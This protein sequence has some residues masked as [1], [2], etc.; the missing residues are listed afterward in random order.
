M[1]SNNP[2]SCVISG[3]FKFK[4]EIDETYDEFQDNN[5]S[6]LAPEKGRLFLPKQR[7]IRLDEIQ[8]MR[9]LPNERDINPNQIEKEFLTQLKRAD[10][11]YLMNL[12]DYIGLSVALEIG[13]ALGD[14]KPIYAKKPIDRENMWTQDWTPGHLEL[15]S[16]YVRVVAIPEIIDDYY[17]SEIIAN[18][19]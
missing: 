11:M 12:E 15:L 8:S 3:S 10:F 9:P 7:I 6:V 17:S 14:R 13:A 1:S 5:I 16:N 19:R 4:P 2:I 18:N